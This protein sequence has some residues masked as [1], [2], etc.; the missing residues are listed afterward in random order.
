MP[1]FLL[2][3]GCR[4]VVFWQKVKTPHPKLRL[5]AKILLSLQKN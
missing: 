5:Y 4:G 1:N 2:F 3:F